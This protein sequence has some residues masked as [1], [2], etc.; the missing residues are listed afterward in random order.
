[1]PLH[2]FLDSSITGTGTQKGREGKTPVLAFNHHAAAGANQ[3]F[4]IRKKI[5]ASTPDFHQ[6][7]TSGE[8]LS[9]WTLEL[10]HMPRSGP[11][12]NYVSIKLDDAKIAWISQVMP[13]LQTPEFANVH[14]YEDIAFTFSKATYTKKSEGS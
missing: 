14:E 8:A 9:K 1:M 2:A 4:V 13:D 3:A 7:M 11:E 5:D 12:C 6:A 10:W